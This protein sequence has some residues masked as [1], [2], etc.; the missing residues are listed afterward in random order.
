MKQENK[1][2][3]KLIDLNDTVL[4][5]EEVSEMLKITVSGVRKRIVRGQMPAHR[6]GKRLYVLKSELVASIRET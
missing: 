2:V 5:L 6:R 1:I 3:S 4:S